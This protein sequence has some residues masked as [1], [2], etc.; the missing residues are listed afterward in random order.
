MYL[1]VFYIYIGRSR[2]NAINSVPTCAEPGLLNHV[3][4]DQFGFE[5]FVVSDYDAWVFMS[6]RDGPTP[7]AKTVPEAAVMGIRAGLDQEGGGNGCVQTL[8]DLVKNGT[9]NASAV[10]AAFRRLFRVRLR[11]GMLDPPTAVPYNMIEKSVAASEPHLGVALRAARE[12]ICLYKNEPVTSRPRAQNKVYTAAYHETLAED[13]DNGGATGAAAL[14][15]SPPS[16]KPWKLLLAGAQG[17]S[18]AALIGNYA[19]S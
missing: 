4:R 19:E 15:L 3:L 1:C 13:E 2:Y 14:P 17:N 7:Y 18:S 10:A 9:V 6:I 16:G 5:G 11:L 8:P 12:S